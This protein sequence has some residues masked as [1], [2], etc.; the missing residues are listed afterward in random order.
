MAHLIGEKKLSV[1][2][3]LYGKKSL[4][5]MGD[6]RGSSYLERKPARGDRRL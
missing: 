2:V 6:S 5:Y 1:I 4:D 3:H